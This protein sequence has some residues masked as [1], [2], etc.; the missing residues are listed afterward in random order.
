MGLYVISMLQLWISHDCSVPP[1]AHDV[2]HRLAESTEDF[3]RHG[4]VQRGVGSAECR[5]RALA[6]TS[7]WVWIGEKTNLRRFLGMFCDK[8]NYGK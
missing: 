6:L 3:Q 4:R 8:P 1:D 7:W 5:R 2:F